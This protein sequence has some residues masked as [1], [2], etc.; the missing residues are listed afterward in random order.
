MAVAVEEKPKKKPKPNKDSPTIKG[1]RGGWRPNSGRPRKIDQYHA[2]LQRN[3]SMEAAKLG[4]PTEDKSDLVVLQQIRDFWLQVVDHEQAQP[5][6]SSYIITLA[7]DRAQG[8][9][10]AR[11]PYMHVRK[12]SVKLGRMNGG[13][14][15]D[16]EAGVSVL[17]ALLQEIDAESR[18]GN[19]K[20]IEHD[21]SPPADNSSG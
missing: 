16:A 12:S 19:G 21:P 4:I 11:A 15:D 20:V 7:L 5:R 9:A 1:Q 2:R 6:P 18:I 3:L 10:T 17:G 14:D 13:D 8:A